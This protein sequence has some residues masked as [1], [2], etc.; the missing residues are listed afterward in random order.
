MNLLGDFFMKVEAKLVMV[1]P[2][3][4]I[5]LFKPVG[6]YIRL[7][8]LWSDRI[9]ALLDSGMYENLGMCTRMG[10]DQKEQY[11]Y[12]RISPDSNLNSKKAPTSKYLK[13]LEKEISLT[14]CCFSVMEEEDLNDLSEDYIIRLY[15]I[16]VNLGIL[17]DNSK[18]VIEKDLYAVLEEILWKWKN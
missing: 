12:F 5:T 9:R 8:A 18:K 15:D 2:Y 11:I 10:N 6:Y 1:C 3:G 14:P 13:G 7:K 16:T 17:M 4:P